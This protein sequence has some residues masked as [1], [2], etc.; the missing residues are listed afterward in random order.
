MPALSPTMSQVIKY[1][2]YNALTVTVSQLLFG[3]AFENTMIDARMIFSSSWTCY[4][5]T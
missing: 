4:R 1:D 2:L 3:A 5:A